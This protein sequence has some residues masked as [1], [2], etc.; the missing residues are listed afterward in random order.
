MDL[1]LKYRQM[2]DVVFS[3][4]KALGIFS[5]VE[6]NSFVLSND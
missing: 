2:D 5:R 6:Q 3:T 1:A 4:K